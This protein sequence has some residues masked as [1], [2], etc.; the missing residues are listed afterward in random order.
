M[1][2]VDHLPRLAKEFL[3]ID[4]V[5]DVL[6]RS[7]AHEAILQF[8]HFVLTFVDGLA[9]NTVGGATVDLTND[10]ILCHID[11]FTGQVTGVGC[12]QRR[13]SQ[14]L[15][16][17][18]R[19]DK[20]IQHRE[21]FTEVGENRF[22]DDVTRRLGHEAAQPGQLANLLA[23]ATRTGVHHQ[24]NRI[25]LIAATV[26]VQHLEHHVR[27]LVGA[28][29][30]DIDH[31]VVT[32]A[33]CDNT[34]AILLVDILDL[35]VCLL[36]FLG[37]LA[38]DD[39]VLKAHRDAGLGRLGEAKLLEFVEHL[40]GLLMAA[41]AV[42]VPNHITQRTLVDD[43]VREANFVRPNLA[44]HHATDG[45]L[46]DLVGHVAVGSFRPDV[47]IG[48]A[49][50]VVDVQRTVCKREEH[51]LLRAEQANVLLLLANH[52]TWFSGQVITTQNDVLRWRDDRLAAG[53]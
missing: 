32:F 1:R 28:V 53:W 52:A 39:H 25:E 15:P 50:H 42:A 40:D 45:G 33:R 44:E 36:N 9:P 13:I 3:R 24:P 16:G 37:L 47:R 12:L 4:R 51:L 10:E 20:V 18:V 43:D 29:G 35:L 31:L 41:V 49:H 2:L 23:V 14:T 26:V 30:P 19:R 38:R 11:E 21:A 7:T 46:D 34:A 17:A 6:D 8:D 27:D 22:F 5:R 48:H